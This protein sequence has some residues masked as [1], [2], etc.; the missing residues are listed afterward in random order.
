MF[1]ENEYVFQVSSWPQIKQPIDLCCISTDQLPFDSAVKPQYQLK[2]ILSYL[3]GLIF[4][5]NQRHIQPA[6]KHVTLSVL[7]FESGLV[8]F[9]LLNMYSTEIGT[10]P[11]SSLT[12]YTFDSLFSRLNLWELYSECDSDCVPLFLFLKNIDRSYVVDV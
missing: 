12:T 1:P 7:F 5:L 2:S 6:L 8:L 4:K 3:S 11:W 9:H 10:S